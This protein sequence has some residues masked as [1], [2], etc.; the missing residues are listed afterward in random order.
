MTTLTLRL[1]AQ[2]IVNQARIACQRQ[3]NCGGEERRA[4]EHWRHHRCLTCP[5]DDVDRLHDA[6]W[7]EVK[8]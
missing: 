3:W 5:L 8:E 2:T 7:E 1:V 6:M 4:G